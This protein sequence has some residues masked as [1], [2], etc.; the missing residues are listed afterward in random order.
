[1]AIVKA[2]LMSLGAT[3]QL[4]KTLV[5]SSWKGVKTAREYVVPANPN[6]VAQAAQRAKM[7]NV[8]AFFRNK[9]QN[10]TLRTAWNVAATISGKAQSGFNA[11]TT[12][13]LA[14]FKVAPAVG[15][16]PTYNLY[17]GTTPTNMQRIDTAY[18]MTGGPRMVTSLSV[19][20][21]KLTF[22]SAN[23]ETGSEDEGV[24]FPAW[25]PASGYVK[26]RA[27]LADRACDV[28]GVL[29]LTV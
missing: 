17:Y 29:A 8:V 27:T 18:P 6:T 21:G 10:P 11:F 4:G 7:A 23:I 3:G 5:M 22:V 1:M 15:D 12:Q 25:V 16:T 13:A 20:G 19:I 28:T 26:I 9:L 24:P 14:M 2:P